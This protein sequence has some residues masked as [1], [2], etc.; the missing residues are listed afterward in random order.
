MEKIRFKDLS[1]WIKIGVIG[2][3]VSI[4]YEIIGFIIGFINAIKL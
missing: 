3:I 1:L 4:S 2:G